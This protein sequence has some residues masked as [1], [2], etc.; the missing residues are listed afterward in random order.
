M[1]LNAHCSFVSWLQTLRSLSSHA[2]VYSGILCLRSEYVLRN[3][4]EYIICNVG[5]TDC[6]APGSNGLKSP[7]YSGDGRGRSG[8]GET[9]ARPKLTWQMTAKYSLLAT[10]MKNCYE[11]LVCAFLL[12]HIL[13][14]MNRLNCQMSRSASVCNFSYNFVVTLTSQT[15]Q[16]H[17]RREHALKLF[18]KNVIIE[19]LLFLLYY[20]IF[21]VFSIWTVRKDFVMKSLSQFC[22]DT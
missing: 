15:V 17:S 14:I 7:A 13:N 6:S 5:R 10:W 18:S 19:V 12:Y 2:E 20:I 1:C 16:G 3:R 22:Q 9:Q 4:S 21:R 11:M 8:S